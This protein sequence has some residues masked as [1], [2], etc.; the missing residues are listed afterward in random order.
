MPYLTQLKVLSFYV[1]TISHCSHLCLLLSLPM[2]LHLTVPN[3]NLVNATTPKSL[4]MNQ[5]NPKILPTPKVISLCYHCIELDQPAHPCSLTRLYTVG[6][7]ASSS[8]TG[9][10]LYW[11]QMLITFGSN[12]IRVKWHVRFTDGFLS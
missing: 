9:L 10:A 12:R 3:K 7:P 4:V 5:F 11:Q 1:L 2:S 8:Q 6:W